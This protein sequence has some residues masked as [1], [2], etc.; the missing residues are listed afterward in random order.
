MEKFKPFKRALPFWCKQEKKVENIRGSAKGLIAVQYIA[1]LTLHCQLQNLT[2]A[3]TERTKDLQQ[4]KKSSIFL[5]EILQRFSEKN[6]NHK[7][8]QALVKWNRSN[9]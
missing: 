3:V 8:P 1:F 9:S 2:P 5:E 6:H 7:A 4:D